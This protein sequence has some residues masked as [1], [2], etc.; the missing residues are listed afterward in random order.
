MTILQR[1]KKRLLFVRRHRKGLF[2]VSYLLMK[3]ESRV[4]V[5]VPVPSAEDVPVL[6]FLN[7]LI[8]FLAKND[9]LSS[10]FIRKQGWSW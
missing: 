5:P 10:P 7:C 3:R 6:D 9:F 4:L 8:F 2:R 1:T